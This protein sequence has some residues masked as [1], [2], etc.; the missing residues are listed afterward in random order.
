MQAILILVIEAFS[1]TMITWL[2]PFNDWF[3]N[4]VNFLVAALQV[5]IAAIQVSLS[6]DFISVG[7]H[8][9]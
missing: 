5:S 6:Y 7:K 9:L 8:V 2:L 3:E 4:L 1:L